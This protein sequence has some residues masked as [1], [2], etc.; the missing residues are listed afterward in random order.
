MTKLGK[1]YIFLLFFFHF[2]HFVL[3]LLIHRMNEKKK[4]YQLVRALALSTTCIYCM[5]IVKAN[6]KKLYF[7][8]VPLYENGNS[9]VP[10]K[11]I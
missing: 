11:S 3:I 9:I 4:C 1:G 6:N 10:H 5:Y 7:N 8:I 2:I